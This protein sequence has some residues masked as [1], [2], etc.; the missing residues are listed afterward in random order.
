MSYWLGV[1]SKEHTLQE[2]LKEDKWFCLPI[3]AKI[4]DGIV[5]YVTARLSKK[6]AGIIGAYELTKKSADSCQCNHYGSFNETL[7]CYEL[8]S[9]HIFLSPVLLADI[10]TNLILKRAQPLRR[11][12]QGTI[13][14]LSKDEFNEFLALRK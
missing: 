13:F 7:Y 11:N 14:N 6:F 10:K 3:T 2:F 9:T 5:I 1:I 12:F 4:G 8:K